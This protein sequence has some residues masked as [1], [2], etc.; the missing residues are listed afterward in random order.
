MNKGSLPIIARSDSD[1]A[2]P[3]DLAEDRFFEVRLLGHLI[4]D[5]PV[6]A[7]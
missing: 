2:I 4:L 7:G 6:G 3:D 5:Y 1:A